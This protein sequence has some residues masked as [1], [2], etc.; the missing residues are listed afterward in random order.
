M[1]GRSPEALAAIKAD[2]IAKRVITF[3]VLWGSRYVE[4]EVIGSYDGHHG[5]S[6][7][8]GAPGGNDHW[9][10]IA[11]THG[12]IVEVSNNADSAYYSMK[13]DGR[14][15]PVAVD[16]IQGLSVIRV[17]DSATREGDEDLLSDVLASGERITAERYWSWLSNIR[18]RKYSR[19]SDA[20]YRGRRLGGIINHPRNADEQAAALASV[21]A[22][23]RACRDGRG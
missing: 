20:Y 13:V 19:S 15:L 6:V 17:G 14:A 22:K 18:A 2:L 5:V 23:S 16:M 9:L 4:I 7:G 1:N 11:I 10:N 21:E 12:R 3:R 8:G